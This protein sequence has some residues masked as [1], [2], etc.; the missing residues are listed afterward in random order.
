SGTYRAG[1][2]ELRL[3]GTTIDQRKTIII[4]SAG[5]VTIEGDI[6]YNNGPYS[7]VRDIPQV[8]IQAPT[9]RIRENVGRIDAW[10]FATTTTQSGVLNTCFANNAVDAPLT[11]TMCNTPL[12]V[13]GPVVADRLYLRRTAGADSQAAATRGNPAEVFNL[14]A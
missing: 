13:N 14:R 8:I 11:S 6:V 12:T 9:I 3:G 4:A 5:T 7:N 2:G 10:L 1:G